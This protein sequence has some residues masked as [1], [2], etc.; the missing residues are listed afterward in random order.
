M[1][2]HYFPRPTVLPRRIT[3][4][5]AGMGSLGA[6]SYDI[7]GIAMYPM[8]Y[9]TVWPELATQLAELYK[10]A[11]NIPWIPSTWLPTVLSLN[12]KNGQ[13]LVPAPTTISGDLV[14]VSWIQS[15]EQKAWWNDFNKRANAVIS[16]YAAQKQEEGRAELERLYA[17]A[18]FWN[19][20]FGATLIDAQANLREAGKNIVGAVAN[21]MK[22]VM[23]GGAILGALYLAKAKLTK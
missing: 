12:G 15:A 21:P 23:I 7:P 10:K 17:D 22:Y 19:T 16:A 14:G 4:K 8:P 18:E 13:I 2:P 1:L 9:A 6:G 3:T 5:L 11:A 20:G